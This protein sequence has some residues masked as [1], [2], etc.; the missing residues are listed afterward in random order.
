[1]IYITANHLRKFYGPE[2]VLNGVTFEIRPGERIGHRVT[3]FGDRPR[4]DPT[5]ARPTDSS[6]RI[7]TEPIR[8]RPAAS[9][10]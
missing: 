5:A 9:S 4:F 1:M 3:V 2:P 7:R 8:P 6:I 10:D